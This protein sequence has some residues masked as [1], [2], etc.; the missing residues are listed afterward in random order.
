MG[1]IAKFKTWVNGEVPDAGDFNKNF[2]D[3]YA[4][5]NGEVVHRDGS[6]AMTGRLLLAALDPT[7][8]DHAVR[9]AYA[10]G[11]AVAG[12]PAGAMWMWPAA[13]PPAG[14][15]VCDGS[16]VSRTTYANLFTAIGTT[17]GGGNGSTTF[18]LPDLRG[19]AP[20][21][22]GQGAGLTNRTLGSKVGTE[23]TSTP[24]NGNVSVPAGSFYG[25][26]ANVHSHDK[27]QPS[28]ALNFIIRT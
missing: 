18:N 1:V 19:R 3:I 15:L 9:K 24:T 6:V 11:L 25:V 22:A 12:A 2:D 4:H 8:A 20:I 27:M 7:Q 14:W 21:G 17:W 13:S 16:A 10:D 28:A 23:V 26:S 5:V